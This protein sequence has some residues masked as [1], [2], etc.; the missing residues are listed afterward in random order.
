[1]DILAQTVNNYLCMSKNILK[2][3]ARGMLGSVLVGTLIV[4]SLWRPGEIQL[5][6]SLSVWPLSGPKAVFLLVFLGLASGLLTVPWSSKKGLNTSFLSALLQCIGITIFL[7]LVLT[8][9][10][11]WGPNQALASLGPIS[12]GGVLLAATLLGTSVG[13]MLRLLFPLIPKQPSRPEL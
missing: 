7:V 9:A 4:L 10:R 2:W 11:S 12:P 6:L 8:V 5:H 3:T 13:W 1:V